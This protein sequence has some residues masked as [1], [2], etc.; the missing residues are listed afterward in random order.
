MERRKDAWLGA[1]DAFG[2]GGRLQTCILVDGPGIRFAIDFG[3]PS[4]IGLRRQGIEPNTLDVI[5]IAHL[6]GDHCGGVPFLLLESMLGSKR[7]TPLTIVGPTGS[8]VHLRA[9]RDVLFPGSDAMQ[10]KFALEHMDSSRPCHHRR[11]EDVQIGRE[12]GFCERPSKGFQPRGPSSS[13]A[14]PPLPKTPGF[15]TRETFLGS[16]RPCPVAP[17]APPARSEGGRRGF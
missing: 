3:T 9:M 10:P 11:Q 2:S 6:H 13:V 1:G 5:V 8:K 14:Q 7:K 12:F 15:L 16:D 17:K 4:L